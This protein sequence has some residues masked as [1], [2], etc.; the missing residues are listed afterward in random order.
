MDSQHRVL[1]DSDV[2]VVDGSI[3]GVGPGLVAPVDA[4]EVDGA[5]GIVMPGMVD[6]HRHMWQTAMRGY[7]ADWTLSQ[8]FVWYY[9]EHGRNFRPQDIYAGNLLSALE[10]LDAGVTTSVDW[11]HG[12]QTVEHADAAVDALEATPG[13]F[14]LA[15]GNIQQGPWEWTASPEFRRFFTRRFDGKGDMLG[16]QIAFDVTGDP[17][18]PERAAFKVAKDLGVTVT[19]HAGVWGA[20]G[21]ASIQLMHDNGC[22]DDKVIFVHASSLSEDSYHRIAASGGHASVSTESEQSAGQG[23]P[24]SWRLRQFDIPISLSHDTTVWWSADLFTAMRT[25]VGADRSRQHFEA[26]LTGDTVTNLDLRCEEVVEWATMG[27][28]R[29]LDLESIVGSVEVGK[30]ADLVLLKNDFS[31]VM[32]PIVNPYGHVVMQAQRNEVHTVLVDGNVVKSEGRLVGVDLA[33]VRETVAQTVEYLADTLGAEA[34]RGGMHPEVPERQKREN[35]YQYT[36][37]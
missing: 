2:L 16:F 26:H 18:F 32:F 11:S 20:T 28:A 36:K 22:M 17:E 27:G 9:L 29:A 34:W 10:A 6:T 4:L 24:S 30:R 3:T 33:H 12:L 21:D 19:T 7:G 8:Y 13:R 31:P 23:Y 35:P 15:Y 1:A 14:V 5:N 25:T 37:K